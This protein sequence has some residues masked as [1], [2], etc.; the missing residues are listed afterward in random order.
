MTAFI[1][2]KF[3]LR[4]FLFIFIVILSINSSLYADEFLGETSANGDGTLKRLRQK[5]A[6]STYPNLC[7]IISVAD[8][9]IELKSTGQVTD[10]DLVFHMSLR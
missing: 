7:L 10:F 5:T 8:N 4:R 3:G 9:L 6:T 2:M 1:D